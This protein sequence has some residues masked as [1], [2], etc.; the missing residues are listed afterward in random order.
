MDSYADV[1]LAL[2]ILGWYTGIWWMARRDQVHP[3]W[4][5]GVRVRPVPVLLLRLCGAYGKSDSLHVPMAMAQL[6]ALGVCAVS[7]ALITVLMPG[8]RQ[9]NALSY[10]AVTP[11]LMYAMGYV[12]MYSAKILRRH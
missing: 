4:S 5:P 3:T 2:L 11:F 8:G 9:Q 1:G 7:I 10:L 12:V 6:T